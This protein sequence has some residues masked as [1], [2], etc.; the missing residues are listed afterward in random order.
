MKKQ[1]RNHMKKQ[2]R[3]HMKK[4]Q[5]N[6]MKKQQKNQIIQI[7]QNQIVVILLWDRKEMSSRKVVLGLSGT[8]RDPMDLI[9]TIGTPVMEIPTT[10]INIVA[11]GK[12][13]MMMVSA[14]QYLGPKL[15][16]IILLWDRKDLSSREVVLGLS[17]TVRDLM[18]L[19]NTIGT[20]VME[21]PTTGINIVA[22]GKVL[23]MMVSA[24]QKLL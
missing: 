3:N 11:N 24:C 10:G 16:V 15:I 1:Q 2:Q 9:N 17:G 12:V 4:Q 6:H 21:I 7:I 8:V 20:P 18:D 13:L 19:M 5:R 14:Y 22:Y 23:M